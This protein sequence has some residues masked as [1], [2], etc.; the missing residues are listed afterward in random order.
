M[1]SAS[2]VGTDDSNGAICLLDVIKF[3]VP[4][5]LNNCSRSDDTEGEAEE[6]EE[7][8]EEENSPNHDGKVANAACCLIIF[9]SVS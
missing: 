1:S 9:P 8:E 2:D 4:L 5:G 3:D 6:E 7:E